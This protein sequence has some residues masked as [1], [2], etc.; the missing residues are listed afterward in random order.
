M[1]TAPRA[2]RSRPPCRVCAPAAAAE[3]EELAAAEPVALPVSPD[4]SVAVAEA[5]VE[6]CRTPVP[7]W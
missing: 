7:D 5:L 4:D 2:P 3:L 6:V 1:A